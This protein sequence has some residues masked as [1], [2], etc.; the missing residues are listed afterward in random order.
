MTYDQLIN[1]LYTAVE[2]FYLLLK[3]LIL[4]TTIT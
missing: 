2:R 3:A 4:T 1:A